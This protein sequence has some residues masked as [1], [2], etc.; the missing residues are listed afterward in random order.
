MPFEKGNKLASLQKG[1]PK[2]RT[3]QWDNL[4]GWLVG[5]GGVAFKSKIASLSVGTELTKPEKEFLEHYKDLLEY[6]QPKLSR[7]ELT[8]K[9]GKDLPTP[10]LG[11]ITQPNGNKK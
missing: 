10:I 4:V 11:G 8:G 6:H 7:A 1:K 2:A 9:D 5:D 3:Q